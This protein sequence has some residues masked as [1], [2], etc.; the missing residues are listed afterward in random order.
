MYIFHWLFSVGIHVVGA[1]FLAIQ[2][3]WSNK[4]RSILTTIGIVIG[5]A[6]VVAVIA[7]LT[8]LKTTVLKK[9]EGYGIKNIYIDVDNKH[10]RHLPW[11][12]L[13]FYPH[14]FDGLLDK[15]PSVEYLTL[16]WHTRQD[17]Q[18]QTKS[19]TG[20]EVIAINA[21]WHEIEN[22]KVIMGRPFSVIDEEKS[23]PTC[24]L[25]T[26]LRDKLGLNIDCIGEKIYIGNLSYRICGII[27]DKVNIG[28]RSKDNIY[29][30]FSHALKRFNPRWLYAV[31]A[32]KSPQKTDD[33][34]AE[35]AF[36]LRQTRRIAPGDYDNFRL[37]VIS[38]YLND[39]KTTASMMTTIASC[40]VSISLLV[41]GV[42]IMNIMLVSVSERTR[43]IGLRKAVGAT[44]FEIMGQFLIEAVM[45]CIFGGVLGVIGGE[46]L[47]IIMK[48]IPQAHLTDAYIP[49][50]A[51]WLSFGFSAFVGIFFGFFP[52][53]KAA[54]LDPIEA[55]RH[56]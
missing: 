17:L 29:I 42:G 1:I 25:T 5:V 16:K 27:E 32:A 41:G 40:V 35:I 15:C 19:E 18:Y 11:R 46:I 52:A 20:V 39:F 13:R 14:Q 24:I 26:G 53:V 8:G 51:I 6:S 10:Y 9:F 22:R 49:A 23:W 47:T 55:L 4:I 21:H 38:K 30:P 12:Q 56:E 37:E 31:A 2:Q 33:A 7:A 43:E 44:P 45:L 3:I 34:R 48:Q 28:E 50:Y 54:R 36:F